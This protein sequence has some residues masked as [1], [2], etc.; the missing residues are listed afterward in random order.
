MQ[1]ASVSL[2]CASSAVGARRASKL[3]VH[4]RHAGRY[5]LEVYPDVGHNVH[6]VRSSFSLSS[7][8]SRPRRAPTLTS[9][10]SSPS[11][12]SPCPAR[13]Q[14]APTRTAETLLDFWERNDR[15]DVLRGVKKV[16]EA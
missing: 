8:S 3:K 4:D 16:G 7:L 9:S 13:S 11:S 5:Q 14:D 2:I 15:T 12:S 1:G 10:L 6:E